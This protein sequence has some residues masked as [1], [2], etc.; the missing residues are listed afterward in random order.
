MNL[1]GYNYNIFYANLIVQQQ[2]KNLMGLK[3][4]ES[5]HVITK[6]NQIMKTARKKEGNK[7]KQLQNRQTTTVITKW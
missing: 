7:T 5:K 6:K 1:D 4:K 2:Q 3:K